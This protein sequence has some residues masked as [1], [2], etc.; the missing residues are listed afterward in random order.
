MLLLRKKRGLSAVAMVIAL[1]WNF[2]VVL[3]AAAVI[4]LCV[5]L[6]LLAILRT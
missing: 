2:D 5:A 6:L 3:V 4:Y 1:L